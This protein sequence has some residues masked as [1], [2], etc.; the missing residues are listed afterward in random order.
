MSDE[1]IIELHEPE[2]RVLNKNPEQ[3]STD[4]QEILEDD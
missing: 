1:I 3:S 4:N 2:G